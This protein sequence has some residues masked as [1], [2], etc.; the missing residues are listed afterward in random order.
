MMDDGRLVFCSCYP[1]RLLISNT[2]GLEI[3]VIPV[4]VNG[5]C[6]TVVNNSTV[7]VIVNHALS[8]PIIDLYDINIKD[9]IESVSL[10]GFEDTYGMTMIDDKLLVGADMILLKID[11][12]TGE[13]LQSIGIHCHPWGIN[14]SG[15][16]IFFSEEYEN[17]IYWYSFTDDKIHTLTLPSIP[18]PM[19]TLRDGSLF[20][21]C[22]DGS[23]QHVSSDGKQFK[24]LEKNQSQVFSYAGRI[25]YNLKQ[26]KMVTYSSKFGMTILHE[27]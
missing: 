3:E 6:L 27:L 21:L 20:V 11:Y 23:I 22:E 1:F 8:Y 19:T 12:Q 7:A 16:K 15:N 2:E 18:Y 10:H 14:V 5:S 26:K 17:N 24:T 13:I 4:Y 25:R 9:K